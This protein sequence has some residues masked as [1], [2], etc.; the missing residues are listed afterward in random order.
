MGQRWHRTSRQIYIFFYGKGN[1]NH[2]LG[3]G[4]SYIKESYQQLTFKGLML[5]IANS[6]QHPST[7]EC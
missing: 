5:D 1:E 4:L 2:E 3:I 7:A 6:R